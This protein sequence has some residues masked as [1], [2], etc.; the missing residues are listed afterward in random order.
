MGIHRRAGGIV[1]HLAISPTIV[2]VSPF[3]T[4]GALMLAHKPDMLEEPVH[5]RQILAYSLIV[6]LVG[7]RRVC[8]AL[9][10]PVW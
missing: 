4:N 10:L 7:P 5:Y 1:R 2:D 6:V 9:V 8:A 3:T